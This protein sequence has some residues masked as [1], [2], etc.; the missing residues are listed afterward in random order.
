MKNNPPKL[1]SQH[2][3]KSELVFSIPLCMLTAHIFVVYLQ[4]DNFF[5]IFFKPGY[6]PAVVASFFIA[7]FLILIVKYTTRYLDK[8]QPWHVNKYQR[9]WLQFFY[10]FFLTI[11]I[12]FGF[13][14]AYFGYYGY[15]ITETE[16]IDAYALPIALYILLI[17][18]YYNSSPPIQ[19]P[20][21]RSV[22]ATEPN[23]GEESTVAHEPIDD[24]PNAE[25]A[26]IVNYAEA[27]KVVYISISDKSVYAKD[28]NGQFVLWHNSLTESRAALPDHLFYQVSRS[29][30]L[31]RDIIGRLEVDARNHRL[32]IVLKE[33]FNNRIDVPDHNILGCE[34]WWNQKSV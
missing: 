13:S 21:V 34:N 4:D 22:V 28:L 14:S 10:G 11:L 32:T 30:I 16:W 23:E 26:R 2:A 19:I 7:F 24:I 20:E 15:H 27:K 33:P 1:R 25:Y 29:L 9:G 5:K 6:T 8:K 31:H 12:E 18:L 17:N 3:L